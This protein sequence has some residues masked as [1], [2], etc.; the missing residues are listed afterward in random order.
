MHLGIKLRWFFAVLCVGGVA[1]PILGRASA[2]A[3]E[4]EISTLRR[5]DTEPVTTERIFE[6]D[7]TQL[8]P[9][10]R[11]WV[12][13]RRVELEGLQVSPLPNGQFGVRARGVRSLTLSYIRKGGGAFQPMSAFPCTQTPDESFATEAGARRAAEAAATVWDETLRSQ[14]AEL[15]M[16]LSR[17]RADDSITALKVGRSL[18]RQW[19]REIE[20]EWREKGYARAA[21]EE[22]KSYRDAARLEGICAKKVGQPLVQPA[23]W[24]KRMEPPAETFD[25][26]PLARAPARRWNGAYSVRLSAVVDHAQLNGQAILDFSAQ[27]SIVSPIWIQGQGS[28]ESLLGL[29]KWGKLIGTGIERVSQGGLAPLVLLEGTSISG[30]D[31]P[32]REFL[33]FETEFFG[34]PAFFAS[35]CDAVLGQDFLARQVVEFKPTS[36]AEVIVWPWKG[37]RSLQ[38]FWVETRVAPHGA[39]VSDSCAIR[40]SG[41]RGKQVYSGGFRWEVS[42]PF[43]PTDARTTPV[44][45]VL[46]QKLYDLECGGQAL[47]REV[48]I[49]REELQQKE[50]RVGAAILGR[51][52]FVLDLPHGRIWFPE[53]IASQPVPQNDSGLEL[54]Y[55][56]SAKRDRVLK[57]RRILRDS[58]A[59]ELRKAGLAPGAV[60]EKIDHKPADE[61]DLWEVEQRLSGVR[62]ST[63]TIQWEGKNG[64]IKIAPLSRALS[65]LTMKRKSS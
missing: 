48:P 18:F 6:L 41:P 4:L 63:V 58:P 65:R 46:G 60:I 40:E 11:R 26:A 39:I 8:N 38:K 35:C 37:Y 51:S 3:E 1:A 45:R 30:L 24:E 36:M 13:N 17:V 21:Q 62:G 59:D 43:S 19:L 2:R 9:H 49:S 57:V 47:A 31:V 16:R 42:E 64:E 50:F 15:S 28:T 22:W 32:L 34:R 33:L 56:L 23:S 44:Q 10:R 5:F 14:R 52:S 7:P 55:V 20:D 12:L 27:K 29:R 54:E 53:G 61:M 25:G